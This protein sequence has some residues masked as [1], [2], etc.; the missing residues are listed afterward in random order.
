VNNLIDGRAIAAQIQRELIFR[1]AELKAR[2]LVPGLAFVR[3]GEDPASKVYV[4]RKEKACAELGIISETHVLSENI[5]THDLLLLIAQLNAAAHLHGILVQAPLPKHIPESVIYSSVLPK[6]DVDG[7]HPV[8]VGNSCSAT[9]P[10]FVPA[11]RRVSWN[12]S[13]APA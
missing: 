9:L 4:G 11:R 5:A 7:F 6:K 1:V 8:N 13:C 12:C 10:V 2:G 3:V